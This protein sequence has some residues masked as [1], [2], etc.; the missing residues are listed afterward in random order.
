MLDA[1]RDHPPFDPMRDTL[2]RSGELMAGFTACDPHSIMQSIDFRSFYYFVVNGAAAPRNK[3]AGRMQALHDSS[4]LQATWAHLEAA[5]RPAAAIMGGHAEGRGSTTYLQ[6]A[7]MAKRLT[8]EGFLMASGGG[9][10]CMEA[11]HLGALLASRAEAELVDAVGLLSAVPNLP[12]A[13]EMVRRDG[14]VDLELVAALHR[15]SAPAVDV[16]NR[17]QQTGGD[18][19]AI[20]TWHYGHEPTSPL[21]THVA[22]YFLNSIRED[23]LLA[24]ASGGIIFSPGR[25][26]T[27]QEVFQGAA[28]NYYGRSFAP[29]V[30][31]DER[32]WTEEL[33][34]RPVL[35]GLFIRL[36][37]MPEDEFESHVLI[38][39]DIDEVVA[40][41]RNANHEASA[42]ARRT[43][44]PATPCDGGRT[45]RWAA[46]P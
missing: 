46:V 1:A 28:R 2:Y 22:K 18:S 14:M 30:F 5:R 44:S 10:G 36:H 27:L 43:W 33:P 25:A 17:Y 4:I 12:D 38:T 26:G 35:E 19:L 15:W 31:W 32:F 40:F 42:G 34:V 9:P 37:G 24:L 11:T 3:H 39:S 45:A 8:E 7:S 13:R 20:P 29:M 16:M 6:V 41:L 23:V 21:A